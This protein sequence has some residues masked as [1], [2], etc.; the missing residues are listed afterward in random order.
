MSTITTTNPA[1]GETIQT[2][3]LMSEQEAVEK[4]EAAQSAFLEWCKLSHSE[5]APYL[6]KI[7]ATLRENAE[8]LAALMTRET[9]KLLKDGKAEVEIC[10]AIFEYTANNGPDALADEERTHG[11]NGSRGVVTY[12]PTGVIYSIQPWNFPLYQPVRVLAANLMAG[13]A[14]VLKHASIC[15]GSG[16]RLRELCIEAGLPEDLFQVILIDHETSDNLI[17]HPLVRGVTLTGSDGAGRHVGSVASKALKKTVLELGSNDAYLVLEDA[18]IETAVKFSLMGRL[19]NNGE[20]CVSA[21]RFV[22]ADK[23]YDAFV[24]A[25]VEQMKAVKMGDPTKDDTQLGP[26]SSEDQFETVKEQVE[27]SLAKGAKALCGGEAPGGTGAYYPATVLV[28]VVPGMPAYDD[29]IFGPVAAVIRAK[30]D[31]DAMRIANDSR[32]GLGGGIFSKDEDRALKL[33]RDHFDTGM[34]RINSFGTADP[35]MP[36]GGVKDSGY[37][38]E[39]GGFGM[40][41]FVN[42]KAVFL[43]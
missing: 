21:K 18:D 6:T 11:A 12:Q 5:R 26:L 15:T 40:K 29:E 2:Y 33:A 9:G 3:P 7:A 36:F 8:E 28:D 31:E 20:T 16:L 39:H 37:G 27:Q 1:T 13:N 19:Y 43:P 23:V 17:E 25:F 30:D 10:A 42:A 38:R 22:V 41:E 14:C 35:N 24:E 34:V 32:Y 4:L